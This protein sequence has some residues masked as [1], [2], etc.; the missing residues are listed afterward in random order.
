[1]KKLITLQVNPYQLI[2]VLKTKT[3]DALSLLGSVLVVFNNGL[4]QKETGEMQKKLFHLLF[5]PNLWQL[6]KVL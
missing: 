4:L 3:L 1:M 6:T 5:D 2:E